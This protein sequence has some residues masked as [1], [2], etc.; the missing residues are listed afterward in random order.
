[1]TTTLGISL[2]AS[3]FG[4]KPPTLRPNEAAATKAVLTSILRNVFFIR[5]HP[6]GKIN[7]FTANAPP[8]QQAAG[9]NKA[10]KS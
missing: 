4:E 6:F 10:C 9:R 8:L 5:F 7:F 2:N 3:A 1:M